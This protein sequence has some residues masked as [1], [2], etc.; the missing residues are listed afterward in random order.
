M[1]LETSDSVPDA[2]MLSSTVYKLIPP[3]VQEPQ[4]PCIF[5]KGRQ[6]KIRHVPYI[7]SG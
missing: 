4:L 3:W 7:S 2:T 1:I 5:P 6:E